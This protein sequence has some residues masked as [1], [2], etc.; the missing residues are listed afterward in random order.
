VEVKRVETG[1]AKKIMPRSTTIFILVLIALA[2]ILGYNY[3]AQPFAGLN[4]IPTE[5]LEQMIVDQEI[6]GDLDKIEQPISETELSQLIALPYLLS[7]DESTQSAVVSWII[8]N[9][10]GAVTLF[11]EKISSSAASLAINKIGDNFDK[12][13]KPLI[14]VDHEG[15][16]VQRLS[17]VGFTDLPSWESVC[18]LNE[19]QRKNLLSTSAQELSQVGVEMIFAPVIDVASQS[20]VLKDRICSSDPTTI[21]QRAAEFIEIFGQQKI[22]PVIK[23]YPGIGS[24]SKDLHRQYDEVDLSEEE[25]LVFKDLLS[26]YQFLGVMSAHVGVKD[27][28][29]DL[30]CS[31][32]S[33]CIGDLND[34]FPQALVFTDA[35]DMS[36]AESYPGVEKPLSLAERSV[37]AILAGN[38]VLVFGPNVKLV[39]IKEVSLAL[40]TTYKSDKEFQRQAKISIKKIRQYKA[41]LRQ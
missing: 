6:E 30:P 31:L 34:Y 13:T 36:S 17:G 32:N 19:A 39:D 7:A 22:W 2:S 5:E 35:L 1:K 15:G 38:D 18:A 10:P 33:D 41:F 37:L 20:A 24:I 26:T 9:Q 14:A 3:F 40:A 23:H 21:T 27:R 12:E 4:S 16:R 11:G 25:I 29:E 28:Y 8:Q